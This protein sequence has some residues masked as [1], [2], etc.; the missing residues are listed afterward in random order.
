MNEWGLLKWTN[1]TNNPNHHYLAIEIENSVSL[2][3]DEMKLRRKK[4]DKDKY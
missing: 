3:S 1:N 4:L 2:I